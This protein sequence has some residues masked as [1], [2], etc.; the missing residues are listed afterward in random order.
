M[1]T[2]ICDEESIRQAPR[3]RCLQYLVK[4]DFSAPRVL[5]VVKQHARRNV[6][7]PE[8]MRR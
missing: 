3:A 5:E 2:A 6:E 7:L 4:A 1:M 8:K